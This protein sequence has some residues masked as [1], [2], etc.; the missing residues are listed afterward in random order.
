MD[1]DEEGPAFARKRLHYDQSSLRQIPSLSLGVLIF[2]CFEFGAR[3]DCSQVS[4]LH[5]RA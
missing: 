4:L 3:S 1:H 5:N 2:Q